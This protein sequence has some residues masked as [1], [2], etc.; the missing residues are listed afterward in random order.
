MKKSSNIIP[1][2]HETKQ[3]SKWQTDLKNLVRDPEELLQLLSL[4][5]DETLKQRL[6]YFSKQFPLR[7]TRDFVGQMA[8]GDPNDPLLRQIL[9]L[10]EEGHQVEGYSLDP[11]QETS[12]FIPERGL[13]HKYKGRALLMVTGACAVN[14]RYCFRRH[15]PYSEQVVTDEALESLVKRVKKE[16]LSEVILSGGDPLMLPTEKLSHIVSRLLSVPGVKTLRLHSRLPVVLPGR[17][18]L[19]FVTWWNS[20]PINRVLVVHA[21]HANE[22]GASHMKALARLENTTLLNQAVLLRGVNDSASAIEALSRSCFDLG[23][24]PYY[25]HLLDQVAGAAH[26]NVPESEAINIMESVRKKLPGY[27]VPRLVREQAGAESKT[28]IC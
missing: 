19:E 27:L 4:E 8:I 21:N 18:D 17:L 13:V 11:L 15:F 14:C 9:P 12:G 28:L 7:V 2:S 25:L 20:I 3:M 16:S 10:L 26:F 1:V 23:I 24:M 5:K 22:L 6:L